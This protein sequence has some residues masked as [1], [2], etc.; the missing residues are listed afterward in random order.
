MKTSLWEIYWIIFPF[1]T[2]I[3]CEQNCFTCTVKG[4]K[5]FC[6]YGFICVTR[7]H[8]ILATGGRHWDWPD[9]NG[10]PEFSCHANGGR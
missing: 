8:P 2:K 9:P 5:P 3:R 10:Q 1:P 4:W 7:T 6:A